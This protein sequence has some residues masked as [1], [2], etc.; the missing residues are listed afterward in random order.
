MKSKNQG[1][2]LVELLLVIAIIAILAGIAVM[3]LNPTKQFGDA[4]NIDRRSDLNSILNAVYQYAIDNNGSLP[5]TI[6]NGTACGV[7]A[8]EICKT[9][10]SCSGLTDVGYYLVSTTAKYL[11]SM[12]IDP[13][14][15][16]TNGTA[17]QIYKNATTNRVTLCAPRAENSSTIS[18]VR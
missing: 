12:P 15:T 5:P 3:A 4:R 13:T 16:S 2:T 14:T 1:F 11:E 9:G 10:G 18:V 6:I 17:Y 8:Q 7:A